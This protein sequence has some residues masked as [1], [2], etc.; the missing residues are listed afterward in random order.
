MAHD[1]AAKRMVGREDAQLPDDAPHS[2][3]QDAEEGDAQGQYV[4]PH[5]PKDCE[6]KHGQVYGRIE[7]NP[8]ECV[9]A[10]A[11]HTVDERT[12]FNG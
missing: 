9:T 12:L 8:M 11:R 10:H 1:L 6:R 7:A 5:E 4:P 3:K 2:E